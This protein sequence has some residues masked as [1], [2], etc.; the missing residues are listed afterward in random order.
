MG[1]KDRDDQQDEDVFDYL[2]VCCTHGKPCPIGEQEKEDKDDDQRSVQHVYENIPQV[3]K[4][5]TARTGNARKD[6]AANYPSSSATHYENIP[7][8]SNFSEMPRVNA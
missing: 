1:N 4:R 8:K 7:A 5:P 6:E 2:S 3:T